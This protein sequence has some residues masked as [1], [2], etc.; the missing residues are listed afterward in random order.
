M[1]TLNF[2]EAAVVSSSANGYLDAKLAASANSLAG[3]L[4]GKFQYQYPGV[5]RS[6]YLAIATRTIA[7]R[8]LAATMSDRDNYR[9]PI[10][11][12]PENWGIGPD[13]ERFLYRV[14]VTVTSA[15]GSQELTYSVDVRS[16]EVLTAAEAREIAEANYTG[17]NLPHQYAE[18]RRSIGRGFTIESELVAV[19]KRR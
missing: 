15:D 16:D 8:N 11:R 1:A 19:G 14:R 2:A 5:T 17:R 7:S 4:L 13:D 12:I 3:L 10:G 6:T 9:P 18:D